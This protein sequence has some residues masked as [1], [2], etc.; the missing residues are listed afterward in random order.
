MVPLRLFLP[1]GLSFYIPTNLQN[2]FRVSIISVYAT[3]LDAI[4]LPITD[5]ENILLSSS[6][7]NFLDFTVAYLVLIS[8]SQP[9][10]AVR[11]TGNVRNVRCKSYDA[12][13]EMIKRTCA[14]DG[15]L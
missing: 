2:V 10:S 3:L 7:R 8:S 12:S 5:E 9:R 15:C 14:E 13:S 11:M 1:S 6:L 4:A